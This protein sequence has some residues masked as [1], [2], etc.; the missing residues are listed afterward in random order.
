MG[1]FFQNRLSDEEIAG[2]LE[3][4]KQQ[5]VIIVD[6]TKVTYDFWPSNS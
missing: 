4:L 1:K 6:G 2:I 5:G 3:G